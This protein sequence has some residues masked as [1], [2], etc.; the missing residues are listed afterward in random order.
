M[1]KPCFGAI[2]LLLAVGCAPPGAKAPALA[3]G[4]DLQNFD[5]TV[6]PQDDFYRYVNGT[7]LETAQIPADRAR[8]GTFLELREQSRLDIQTIIEETAARPDLQAGSEE[9]KIGDLYLSFMDTTAIEA[10]GMDPLREDLAAIEAVSNRDELLA[11]IGRMLID[12][13][14]TPFNWYIDQDDKDPENY[15][16][17]IV[18]SGLG[19]PDRDYY[20]KE[21][22]RFVQ[23]RAAYAQYLGDLLNLGEQTD[24]GAKAARIVEIETA[25]AEHHWTRTENRDNEK[26]YNKKSVAELNALSPN[27]NWTK[28]LKHFGAPEVE[29]VILRQPSYLEAFDK[30][31]QDVSVEDWKSYLTAK[32][33][34]DAA[35]FMSKPFVDLN[36]D[37]Y[38]RTLRGVE[39]NEVRWKRG[40]NLVNGSVGE[41]VGKLYVARHFVPEAKER[42]SHLVDNLLVAFRGRLD[43]LD[44]MSAETK[45]AARV[46]LEKFN[47]KIGYPDVWRDYSALAITRGDLMDNLRNVSRFQTS[48]ELGKLGGPVDRNEWFMTPQRVNAYYNPNMNEIVFPAAILQP[49]FFNFE[50]DDAVNYGGIGAVIGHEITHGFDDRGRKYDGDGNLRDWWT[51]E[52]GN[53]FEKR[54]QVVIDQYNGYVPID[55]LHVNG[56][57]TLGENIGDIGGLTVAYYAYKKSLGGKES[58]VI[59]GFTGEQRFFIG[60]GQVWRRLARDD[61]VRRLLLVDPHSPGQYRVTGVVSNMPEFYEAFNVQPGDPLYRDEDIRVNIW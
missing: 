7:W 28:L 58:K 51:E 44:W 34:R 15:I 13:I 17:N 8:T 37:F 54:A 57:L 35:P 22:E 32:S 23:I 24:A 55:T 45:V 16:L 20:F 19:L 41:A 59:D 3:S 30:V 43:Q 6:R 56:E 25:M 27:F 39:E 53:E 60:W 10:L 47:T 46:K 38:R 61:E 14:Q 49:P 42:M 21:E 29:Q 12:D 31:Y 48:Q 50:A 36:F 2:L 4:I 11:L 33:I 1:N 26:T 5:T 40:V 52:D 9:Q 18:Q